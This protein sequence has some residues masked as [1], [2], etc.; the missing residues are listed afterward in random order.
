M[1][2]N[3]QKMQRQLTVILLWLT[4]AVV[5][6][7]AIP[8]TVDLALNIYL[9]FWGDYVNYGSSYRGSLFIRQFLVV[10]LAT[11]YVAGII[12]GAEYHTRNFNT[13]R[14]WR[15]FTITFA[16]EG[17]LLLLAAIL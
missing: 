4:S 15:F 2:N 10:P 16:I 13:P 9:P 17:G 3:R 8:Q 5:G 12:G 1:P 6:L 14:S 7:I 11:L